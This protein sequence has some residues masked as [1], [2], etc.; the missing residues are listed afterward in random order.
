MIEIDWNPDRRALR[1]WGVVMAAAMAVVGSLFHFVD[2]GVFRAG[3]GMAPFMWGFGAAALLTAGTGSRLGRPVYLAWMGFAWFVGTALGLIALAVVFYGVV[4]P[5][6]IV[7]RL[8]G[9][10]RLDVRSVRGG[11]RTTRWHPLPQA[12]HDPARQF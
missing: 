1:K 6:A 3:H 2:W 10:D 9:R 8:A 4:T 5:M 11:P 12:P 7:A